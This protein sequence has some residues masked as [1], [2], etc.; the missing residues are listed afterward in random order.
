MTCFP[1]NFCKLPSLFFLS[2]KKKYI[3]A[4]SVSL[5]E[6]K[7]DWSVCTVTDV[8]TVF[9]YTRLQIH[10]I[11]SRKHFKP[12][13]MRNTKTHPLF[14]C[15]PSNSCKTVSSKSSEWP[16]W[17]VKEVIEVTALAF[18]H[19]ICL[20]ILANKMAALFTV[21]VAEGFCPS[22]TLWWKIQFT[23]EKICS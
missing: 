17:K 4:I 13:D 15:F 5:N 11:P 6:L 20:Q 12:R 9:N 18:S 8:S 1:K 10:Y 3:V 7:P 22:T 16:V 14:I 21:C 23:V 2:L 19:V